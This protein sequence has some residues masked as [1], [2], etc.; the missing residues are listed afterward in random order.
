VV[1][2]HGRPRGP[3]D[4]SAGSPFEQ[5]LEFV[6]DAIVGIGR[7]GRIVLV[8]G[9]AEELF[10]YRRGHLIGKTIEALV[11]QRHRTQHARCRETFFA[12]PY[13]RRMGAGLELIALRGDGTELPVEI[14]LSHLELHGETIAVAA[15]RTRGRTPSCATAG[16]G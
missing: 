12:E 3:R 10:G 8:N 16:A 1:P 5:F 9:H 2:V 14:S 7:D 11:P 4:G 15:V 13:E 6:P